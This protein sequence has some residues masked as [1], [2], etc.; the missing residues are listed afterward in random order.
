L[1][2]TPVHSRQPQLSG[3]RV[4]SPPNLH[5]RLPDT[6][7][8][9][10]PIK[11]AESVLIDSQAVYQQL[12]RVLLVIS[13]TTLGPEIIKRGILGQKPILGRTTSKKGINNTLFYAL[14]TH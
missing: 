3:P 9:G 4:P 6:A 11:Y 12:L 2:K 14:I 7:Y 13:F 5:V 10:S 1:G 8:L